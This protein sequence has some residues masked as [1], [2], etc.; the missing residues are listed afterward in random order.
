MS[1]PPSPTLILA[2]VGTQDHR[3][4]AGASSLSLPP[5]RI[6]AH[7]VSAFAG[8]TGLSDDFLDGPAV[9]GR[10]ECVQ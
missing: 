9:R 4:D 3:F 10:K 7:W 5:R 6:A 1:L 2:K 8:M